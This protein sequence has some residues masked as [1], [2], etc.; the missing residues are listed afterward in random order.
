MEKSK[1]SSFIKIRLIEKQGF[2]L[3]GMGRK[4]PSS[5][6]HCFIKINVFVRQCETCSSIF[7]LLKIL[8]KGF[9][10]T[11]MQFTINC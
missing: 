9:K 10:I 4:S 6:K 1:K 8:I 5:E 2:S 7:M 11:T 3:S